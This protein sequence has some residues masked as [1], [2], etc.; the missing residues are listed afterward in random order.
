[1][2]PR[3]RQLL[4]DAMIAASL[5]TAVAVAQAAYT[6]VAGRAPAC[7]R[8]RANDA[9]PPHPYAACAFAI[10]EECRKLEWWPE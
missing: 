5:I 4:R 10:A 9:A 3:A 6:R 1:M 7:C 2:S 8:W